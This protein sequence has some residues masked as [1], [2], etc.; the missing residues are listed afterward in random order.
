MLSYPEVTPPLKA[1]SSDNGVRLQKRDD[2]LAGSGHAD[3]GTSLRGRSAFDW[4]RV[5][6]PPVAALGWHHG[7]QS[8]ASTR[9]SFSVRSGFSELFG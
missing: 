8:L 9:P 1:S 5:A 7:G 4:L 2:P 3:Q 6:D